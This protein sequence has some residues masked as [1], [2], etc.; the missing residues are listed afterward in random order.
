M[1]DAPSERLFW[2]LVAQQGLIAIGADVSNAFAEAPASH[3]PLYMFIDETFR[4][5]WF[6]HLKR[7]P[8]PKECT[9]VPVCKAIQGHPKSP[10]L[11]EKHI[12]KILREMNFTPT[13]HEPCLYWGTVDGNIVLF[14]RQVDDFSVAATNAS[15]CSQIISVKNILRRCWRRTPGY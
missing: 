1:L 2:A 12:D 7:P 9:V 5:W 14:L 4:D 6:N 15:T 11:W 10:R 3:A 13:R 8:I